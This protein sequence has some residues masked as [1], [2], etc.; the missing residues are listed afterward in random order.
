MEIII[1]FLCQTFSIDNV[2][3]GSVCKQTSSSRCPATKKTLKKSK[4]GHVCKQPLTQTQQSVGPGHAERIFSPSRRVRGQARAVG[5]P[6][7]PKS[8]DR[9]LGRAAAATKLS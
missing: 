6:Y 8:G 1:V 7:D 3:V 2:D 5:S 9:C 4:K